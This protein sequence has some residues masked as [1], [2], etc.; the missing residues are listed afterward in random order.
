MALTLH[1]ALTGVVNWG[2]AAVAPYDVTSSFAFQGTTFQFPKYHAKIY[3]CSADFCTGSPLANEKTQ[4]I[5]CMTNYV[6]QT[7]DLVVTGSPVFLNLIRMRTSGWSYCAPEKWD[8]GNTDYTGKI[9]VDLLDLY[10]K[11]RDCDPA[12]STPWCLGTL[13]DKGF[14]GVLVYTPVA[15]DIFAGLRYRAMD[16]VVIP[17]WEKFAVNFV[18][19]QQPRALQLIMKSMNL[20]SAGQAVQFFQG[21]NPTA[22]IPSTIDD[23]QITL[24]RDWFINL[25]VFT[26][27]LH[28]FFC[29]VRV[30][31]NIVILIFAIKNVVAILKAGAI[32]YISNTPLFFFAN[33]LSFVI[34]FPRIFSVFTN[35][36]YGLHGPSYLEL[37]YMMVYSDIDIPIL[38]CSMLAALSEWCMVIVRVPNNKVRNGVKALLAVVV[39]VVGAYL[40]SLLGYQVSI[41]QANWDVSKLMGRLTIAFS[42]IF[43]GTSLLVIIK[44]FLVSKASS[45]TTVMAV[46]KRLLKY[47]LGIGRNFGSYVTHETKHFIYFYLGQVAI[48]LFKSG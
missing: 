32:N 10:L 1:V 48:L 27:P 2:P 34:P 17:E 41:G 25:Y 9:A 6:K 12:C 23:L 46:T 16:N 21:K 31:L 39:I 15:A 11:T 33:F 44:L 26:Q 7:P 14:A 42:G 5:A 3:G 18:Q 24:V 13:V 20:S 30:L 28:Q 47:S 43:L 4:R 36:S 19:L 38:I 45:S 8:W 40:Y 37:K 29:W 35:S 22:P